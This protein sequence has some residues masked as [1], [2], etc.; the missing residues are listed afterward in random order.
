MESCTY[1]HCHR[2]GSPLPRGDQPRLGGPAQRGPRPKGVWSCGGYFSRDGSTFGLHAES[3]VH[4]FLFLTVKMIVLSNQH[5]THHDVK[6]QGDV[7]GINSHSPKKNV[8]KVDCFVTIVNCEAVEL[9]CLVVTFRLC[10]MW[11]CGEATARDGTLC[12][13]VNRHHKAED[14]CF[15]W[16]PP[17]PHTGQLLKMPQHLTLLSIEPTTSA[18]PASPCHGF[19]LHKACFGMGLTEDATRRHR[20][21]TVACPTTYLVVVFFD[22]QEAL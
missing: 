11:R 4:L 14:P 12:L 19:I 17:F 9:L 2:G 16:P 22:E 8:H 5:C 3:A 13:P 10:T 1:P 6:L 21:L 18:G 7:H 15:C 20:Y